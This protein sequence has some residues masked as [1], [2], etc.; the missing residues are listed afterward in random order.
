M[1]RPTAMRREKLKNGSVKYF[2]AIFNIF[3]FPSIQGRR[4]KVFQNASNSLIDA[5]FER[6]S[7][8]SPLEKGDPDF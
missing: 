4:Q 6:I 7:P 8:F 3:I 1:K 5:P 2:A